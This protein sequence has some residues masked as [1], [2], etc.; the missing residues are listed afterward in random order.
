MLTVTGTRV[1]VR[2]LADPQSEIV[3]QV[4]HGAELTATGRKQN[5]MVEIVPPEAVAAWVYSEL[6]RD[7]RVAASSV[8]VRSGP[9]I[10]YRSIGKVAKGS[11][12]KVRESVG[13]W[14]KI[15]PPATCRVWISSSYVSGG[16]QPEGNPK[17]VATP[18]GS[19]GEELKRL[20]NEEKPAPGGGDRVTP[21]PTVVPLEP[22]VGEHSQEHLVAVKDH[23]ANPPNGVVGQ[24]RKS[25]Q[26]NGSE[27]GMKPQPIEHEPVVVVQPQSIVRQEL[28]IKPVVCDEPLVK[29]RK[30]DALE[31]EMVKR[32][33]LVKGIS[34]GKPIVVSGIIRLAPFFPLR[35]PSSYR[36]VVTD[37]H[38]HSKSKVGCYLIGDQARIAALSG[39][40]VKVI[41]KKYWVKGVKDPVVMVS[42]LCRP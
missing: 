42:A 37:P 33:Q 27:R 20:L 18:V 12:I 21:K 26:A 32:L 11:A 29:E 7:G 30:P 16:A 34:Q 41:G 8:R 14:V 23:G 31:V 28:E 24:P 17:V 35:R 13:D 22:I 39:K 10:G 4:T 15:V 6:V 5:G 40:P 25:D 19:A 36:L 9:G 1:N 3:G 38:Q 2:A